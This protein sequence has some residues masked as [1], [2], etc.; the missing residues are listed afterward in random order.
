MIARMEER[1]G[2]NHRQLNPAPS[3]YPKAPKSLGL[4]PTDSND[5]NLPLPP[6]DWPHAPVHRLTENGVYM[7]TGAT[8][9][10]RFLFTSAE[11]R[12]LLEGLLLSLSKQHH[13]KL[14]AWAVFRSLVRTNCFPGANQ[15][16]LWNENRPRRCL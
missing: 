6:K 2:G 3:V 12:S 5:L 8:I 11:K 4:A 14:E 15:D 10:K 13:W 1:T 9:H 7:V 16:R